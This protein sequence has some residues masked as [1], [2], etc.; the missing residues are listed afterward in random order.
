M[1]KRIL[2]IVNLPLVAVGVFILMLTFFLPITN[3]NVI[4]VVAWL[5]IMVG[6]VGYVVSQNENE[7]FR[8]EA[9]CKKRSYTKQTMADKHK[10]AIA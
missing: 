4:N 5:L 6:A 3:T 1:R 7:S 2:Q 10:Q 9:S 8:H